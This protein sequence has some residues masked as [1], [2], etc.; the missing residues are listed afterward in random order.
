MTL[1]AH[2]TP[3]FQPKGNCQGKQKPCCLKFQGYEPL[4]STALFMVQRRR[5]EC[6]FEC[7]DGTALHSW[8]LHNLIISPSIDLMSLS[9]VQC[10][11]LRYQVAFPCTS[12]SWCLCPTLILR[13]SCTPRFF[14]EGTA[15]SACEQ[16]PTEFPWANSCQFDKNTKKGWAQVEP[17]LSNTAGNIWK[18]G[19]NLAATYS[20]ICQP[21]STPR[22]LS[23]PGC[24]SLGKRQAS[25]PDLS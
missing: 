25:F 21:A 5:S 15:C 23:R 4:G 9:G 3:I 11:S 2:G 16:G 19:G 1:Q 20:N 24:V 12:T 14:K 18:P 10:S 17:K 6:C 8:R 13:L 7:L 22:L